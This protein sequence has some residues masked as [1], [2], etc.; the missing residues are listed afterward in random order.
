MKNLLFIGMICAFMFGLTG[1]AMAGAMPCAAMASGQMADN[2][3]MMDCGNMDMS[4][5]QDGDPQN[6]C[7]GDCDAMM[8][9][10]GMSATLY[11]GVAASEKR[12]YSA[13]HIA[14]GASQS[15]LGLFSPPEIKPPIFA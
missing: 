6:C 8:Q 9:C 15:P 11:A 14:I 1:Q 2:M 10:S 7:K 4:E 5:S 12:E 3:A 13:A